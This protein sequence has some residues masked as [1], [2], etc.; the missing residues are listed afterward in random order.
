MV[1]YTQGEHDMSQQESV[2]P[3]NERPSHIYYNS[4]QENAQESEARP[5]YWSTQPNTGNIPKNEHP[6]N[7]EESIATMPPIPLYSYKAQD[8]PSM[9]NN[10]DTPPQQL[11]RQ[12]Q[13]FSPDGDA[14]EHGYQPYGNYSRQV[15]PWARPQRGNHVGRVIFLIIAGFLLIKPLLLL[16]GAL[17]FAAGLFFLLLLLAVFAVIALVIAS[18]ALG[19]P[20]LFGM[21]RKHGPLRRWRGY[22]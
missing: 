19:R 17:L 14:L 6:A 9:Q 15:P 2:P 21:F 12:R 4:V 18:V 16:L 10:T 8:R 13:Q 11:G 7:F 20:L 5:Y 1:P 3:Q 22:I